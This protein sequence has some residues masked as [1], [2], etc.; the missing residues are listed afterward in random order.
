M[1][2]ETTRKVYLQPNAVVRLT[3]EEDV[4]RTSQ[5]TE[6]VGDDY[7]VKP[8]SNWGNIWGGNAQ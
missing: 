4:I 3:L 8:G 2:Q 5:P 6:Q 7:A 1:K